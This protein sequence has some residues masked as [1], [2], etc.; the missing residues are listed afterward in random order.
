[1]RDA[2][3]IYSYPRTDP[4]EAH[5]LRHRY[6]WTNR[7]F[8]RCGAGALY[9]YC[10]V[11]RRPGAAKLHRSRAR[12]AAALQRRVVASVGGSARW[13]LAEPASDC[14]RGLVRTARD[15]TQSVPHRTTRRRAHLV[16]G[17]RTEVYVRDIC[18]AGRGGRARV[19]FNQLD[20]VDRPAG[21]DAVLV[22]PA[23]PA[24]LRR[25]RSARSRSQ[26]AGA[27]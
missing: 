2:R 3:R 16:R 27:L 18:D 21:G 17:A 6:R 8:R 7:R 26:A 14:V 19:F 20:R 9:R 12:R 4:A 15:R 11:T 22:R 25:G 13:L 1:Y 23:A 10:D 24:R 5:A